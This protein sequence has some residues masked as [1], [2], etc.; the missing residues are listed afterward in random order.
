M[1][2]FFFFFL[3]YTSV[4]TGGIEKIV[5]VPAALVIGFI[6]FY[7]PYHRVGDDGE[8]K[9]LTS[10]GG[11]PPAGFGNGS[12]ASCTVPALLYDRHK[13]AAARKRP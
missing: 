3:L 4:N 5:L 13:V 6:S 11:P 1:N 7:T 12:R 2:K 8:K 9:P 10:A